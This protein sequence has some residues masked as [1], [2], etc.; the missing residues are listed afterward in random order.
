MRVLVVEDSRVVSAYVL[1]IL[2]QTPTFSVVG[3]TGDGQQAIDMAE[4]LAPD[5]ILMD[6]HLDTL[7]GIEA[8]RQIMALRP[9]PIV[10]LSGVLERA[11]ANLTFEAFRAGAVE[12][13]AKPDGLGSR[14]IAG[15][16]DSLLRTLR[17]M[18]QARVIRR[19]GGAER[20]MNLPYESTSP[21]RPTPELVVIG[22]STGGPQ[23]LM[24]ILLAFPVP[25][26][27]P[28]LIAQHIARG[29]GRGMVDWLCTTG[30]D[31]RAPEPGER[32]TAGRV[33]VGPD[34]GHMECADRRSLHVSADPV[35]SV[36]PSVDRLMQSAA[37]TY[38]A[39]ACGVLL[40][41]MGRDG[42][43]GLLSMRKTGAI[44]VA[45][46]EESCVVF[47]MPGTAIALGAAQYV[48]DAKAIPSK[49]CEWLGIHP[50]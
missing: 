29:F 17:V 41:G 19:F 30:H 8:I 43:E 50:R 46:N 18:S 40:T 16:R 49:V 32:I 1:T 36:A 25:F 14:E 2:K 45:Q 11:E 44:T 22:A 28:I 21:S 47:G 12:V 20:R 3:L 34:D 7:D 38:G 24:D 37:R 27:V 9:T 26:P 6:L 15:F 5:V 35:A 23:V 10:V 39:A 4:R 33:Y 42:A 31:V 13:L 48:C